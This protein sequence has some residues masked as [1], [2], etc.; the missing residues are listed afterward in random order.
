MWCV[1]LSNDP[2][3]EK[4]LEF[5]IECTEEFSNEQY[6]YQSY[7]RQLIKQQQQQQLYLAKRVR[8]DLA[9]LGKR[10]GARGRGVAA[11]R[12]LGGASERL[13]CD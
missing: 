10:V 8:G 2:F 6:T 13:V 3:L 4:N 12:G 1:Q 7:Q 11:R 9:Q 5:M